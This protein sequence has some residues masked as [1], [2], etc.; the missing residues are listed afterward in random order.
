LNIDLF[1][2]TINWKEE[3]APILKKYKL[4]KHPLEFKNLFQLLTMVILSAQDSDEN[5]NK[6]APN[7]FYRFP[8]METLAKSNNNEILSYL[9][10]VK[11]FENKSKWIV[12]TAKIIQKNDSIP[13][14][15]KGLTNLKGI[16]RKSANV[17]MREA[18]VSLE[19]IM[20]DLHV[21]RVAPRIGLITATKDGIKA[22]KELMFALPREIWNDIGMVISFLGR[23]ICRPIPKCSQ[24]PIN[25]CCK[26]YK[27]LI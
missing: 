25:S 23:E 2:N 26:Y 24:C 10:T 18:N 12:E 11:Y 5:I 19:G 22:E 9:N 7:F 17:I 1:N 20:V 21:L 8:N 4:Q 13:L 27:K 6:I 14:T 16:G 3:L 15:M